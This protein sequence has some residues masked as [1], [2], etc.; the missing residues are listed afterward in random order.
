M[1][2]PALRQLM[3]AYLHQDYDLIGDVWENV[4]AF[5]T[6]SPDLAVLLPGEVAW[7]LAN[8]PDEAELE[9]FVDTLG[10]QLGPLDDEGGYRGWL[11]EIARRVAAATG[12]TNSN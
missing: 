3:S 11:T 10:C 12:Q 4:D 8:Y 6:E 1:Q 7:T 5:V 9:R 2:T